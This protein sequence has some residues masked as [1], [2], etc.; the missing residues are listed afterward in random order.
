MIEER[1]RGCYLNPF[2][3][4]W[5]LPKFSEYY[6]IQQEPQPYLPFA[7]GVQWILSPTQPT[8]SKQQV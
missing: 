4:S 3:V 7:Q 6:Y 2:P 1:V 8:M 5:I